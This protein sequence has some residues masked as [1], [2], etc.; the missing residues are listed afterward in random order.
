M[1]GSLNSVYTGQTLTLKWSLGVNIT[2]KK[3]NKWLT[4]AIV[5]GEVVVATS[6]LNA[7]GILVFLDNLWQSPIL[8]SSFVMIIMRHRK[9]D[10]PTS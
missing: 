1:V 7:Q 2:R 10:K 4:V 5:V 6:L 3:T 8:F 9:I